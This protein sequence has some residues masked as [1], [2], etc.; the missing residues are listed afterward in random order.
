MKLSANAKCFILNADLGGKQVRHHFFVSGEIDEQPQ[1]KQAHLRRRRLRE[2]VQPETAI[3]ST[4]LGRQNS[5]HLQK[6]RIEQLMN[7][8]YDN[9]E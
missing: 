2:V 9:G 7:T 6:D 8:N 1:R 3:E 5:L 4:N